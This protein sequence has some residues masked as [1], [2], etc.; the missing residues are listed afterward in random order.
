MTKLEALAASVAVGEA[1]GLIRV[2]LDA[3]RRGA[4]RSGL[5]DSLDR[6]LASLER[7]YHKR[8]VDM[9]SKAAHAKKRPAR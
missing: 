5:D 4:T 1:R 3:W 7:A 6:A 8:A 2:T 9:H